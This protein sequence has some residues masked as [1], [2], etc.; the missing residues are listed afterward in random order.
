MCFLI[1]SVWQNSP[2]DIEFPGDREDNYGR[3]ENLEL[4]E[5]GESSILYLLQQS[6]LLKL[7]DA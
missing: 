5:A 3:I 7:T 6:F 2:V 1:C 4:T